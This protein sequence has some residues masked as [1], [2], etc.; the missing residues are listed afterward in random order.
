MGAE[1]ADDEG[2]AGLRRIGAPGRL[3]AVGFAR[4]GS[5][6][7]RELDLHD[8]HAWCETFGVTTLATAMPSLRAASASAMSRQSV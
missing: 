5:P 7:E 8:A 6:A 4:A 3:L 2:S 1:I